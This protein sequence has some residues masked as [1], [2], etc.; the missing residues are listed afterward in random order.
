MIQDHL[1]SDS[2]TI[3]DMGWVPYLGVVED[4]HHTLRYNTVNKQ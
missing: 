3:L 4:V 2:I 1:A